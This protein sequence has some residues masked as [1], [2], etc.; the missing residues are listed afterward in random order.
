MTR[1]IAYALMLAAAATFAVAAATR[2][3]SGSAHRP[4]LTARAPILVSRPGGFFDYL[5]MDA[6]MRRL[7]AV[8]SSAQTLDVIDIDH[9]RVERRIRVGSGHG[10][11]VDARDGKYFVG[12]DDRTVAVIDRQTLKKVRGIALPGP[13]DDIEF[14]PRNG[15][16]YVDSHAET[17]ADLWVVDPRQDRVV[18]TIR[19]GPKLEFVQYDPV[20]NLLYQNVE[21]SD[22]VA[23]IDPQTNRTWRWW[24]VPVHRPHGLAVDG[25]RRRL[26]TIGA[27]GRLAVLDVG[28]GHVL[29]VVGVVPRVDQIAADSS[30]GRVYVPSVDGKLSVVQENA[31]AAALAGTVPIPTGAHT[32]AI[33]PMTHAVW[34]AYGATDGD[35][36][37][38][39]TLSAR[40]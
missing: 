14:D 26:L 36:V 27:H 30:S 28:S 7:L 25:R 19:V 40:E 34:I 20:S 21:G 18:A 33:D 24:S 2:M 11:A 22:R 29:G 39:L 35:Y 38:K 31:R 13:A 16:L 37:M 3:S 23:V 32:L 8:H 6:Q 17:G 5:T 10:V 9:G 12:T 4:L 15:L 1:Y